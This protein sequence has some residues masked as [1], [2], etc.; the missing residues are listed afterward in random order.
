MSKKPLIHIIAGARPNFMKISPLVEALC[1][2]AKEKGG[3][4]CPGVR[5]IHTGQHYDLD[6]SDVF[7]NDLGIP[8]PDYYLEV[9][10]GSQ[11]EQTARTMV[12]YEKVLLQDRPDLVI[13]VGDVNSTLACSL[14]GKKMG[15]RV[16]HVEAGLRSFDMT[17]P[18]E[19]NRKLTDAISDLLFVTEEAGNRNLR[20]EGIPEER[21]YFV[22]NVMIDT[23]RKNLLK[24][25]N[26]DFSPAGPLKSF[27]HG[28]G[29]YA[30]LTL[31]RPSNVD[32]KEDLYRVWS[33][34]R[35]IAVDV[36]ILFPVHPRTKNR[37]EEHD[38]DVSNIC[39]VA[40]LGYLDMLYAVKGSTL[41][42]T[43]SG[44]LQEETTTLGIPCVTIRENTE[45]PSTVDIGTNYLAG[46]DPGS[47]LA[48]AR[49]ILSGHP[50]K[51]G[52]PPHWDGHAAERIADIILREMKKGGGIR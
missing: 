28:K 14:T 49:E 23:L 38:L 26:G 51:G 16:A 3:E 8:Q 37:I 31:H 36:P 47:I 35:G 9:G 39:M 17:M 6:M 2:R 21:I 29:R 43:D 13:V 30:V 12:A 25:E 5:I 7:F 41:V 33:A 27:L 10:S 19:I 11:A 32:R 24:L 4:S 44:G 46:T 48:A 1:S 34:I 18:E 40:P 22:G 50:K 45:R 20:N 52:I 15:I 42:L